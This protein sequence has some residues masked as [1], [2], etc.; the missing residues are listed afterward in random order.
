MTIVT[1]HG[2]AKEQPSA[3]DHK[4]THLMAVMVRSITQGTLQQ[5]V[6]DLVRQE[7]SDRLIRLRTVHGTA[8]VTCEG[9]SVWADAATDDLFSSL[10]VVPSTLLF[11]SPGYDDGVQSSRISKNIS[12]DSS[13]PSKPCHPLLMALTIRIESMPGSTL[14]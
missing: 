8:F 12:D 1:I 10:T 11:G 7:S 4:T 14:A 9:Q 13:K 2:K 6:I 5:Q 3:Q